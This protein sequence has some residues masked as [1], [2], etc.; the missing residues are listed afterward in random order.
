MSTKA[1]PLPIAKTCAC[2]HCCGMC[3][4]SGSDGQRE[5]TAGTEA[6]S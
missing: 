5:E 4:A 2:G 1:E 6:R 3:C